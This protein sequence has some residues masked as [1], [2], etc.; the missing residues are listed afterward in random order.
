MVSVF[1]PARVIMEA[2]S[3]ARPSLPAGSCA[4]PT[5]NSS[6]MF[7]CGRM[8]FCSSSGTPAAGVDAREPG[9]ISMS[10]GRITGTDSPPLTPPIRSPDPGC[11]SNVD[12]LGGRRSMPAGSGS[13]DNVATMSPL[14]VKYFLAVF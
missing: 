13:W 11:I 5:V 10:G 7:N 8:D 3:A 2:V 9:A 1:D 14:L 4:D 12:G 6:L